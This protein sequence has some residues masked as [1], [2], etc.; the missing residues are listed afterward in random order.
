MTTTI[1]KPATGS[2][3]FSDSGC[4]FISRDVSWVDFNARVLEEAAFPENFLLDRLRFIAI[5]SSN[6]DEFFAVRAAGLQ[7][8][9][10]AGIMTG[11][12]AGNSPE[13]Q[14][15]IIRQK[16]FAGIEKQYRILQYELLPLLSD[17][18]IKLSIWK[19]L[20]SQQQEKLTALFI[21]DIMPF[22]TPV[23]IEPEKNFPVIHSGVIAIAVSLK[24]PRSKDKKTIILEVPE[25]LDRFIRI[26]GRS[27]ENEQTFIL[28]EEV[29][30]A[31]ITRFFPHS[32]VE[33]AQIFRLIRDMDYTISPQDGNNLINVLRKKLQQCAISTPVKLDYSTLIHDSKL[34]KLLIKKLNLTKKQCFPIPG[35]LH[36]KQFEELIIKSNRKNLLEPPWPSTL[37]SWYLKYP[38]VIEAIRDRKNLLLV[39]PYHDFAPTLRFLQETANDPAVVAIKQTLYRVSG[40]SPVVQALLNAARNGKQVTVLVELK[41]RFNEKSNIKWAEMLTHA[42]ANVIYGIP[43]LKVHCKALLVTRKENNTSTSYLHLG[44]GNYNDVTAK[45]YTDLGLFTNDRQLTADTERL[46]DLFS[47]NSKEPDGRQKISIAPFNLREKLTALIRRETA[48]GCRGRIIA[49]I[50][51]FSDPALITLIHEAANAG[52]KIDLIV[53]GICCLSPLPGEKNLR[54]ISIIDRYLEHSRIFYFANAGKEELYAS[55]ADWMPRNLD[56]RIETMFPITD[57]ESKAVIMQILQFH[58]EDNCKQRQL[59]PT[60]NYTT[61]FPVPGEEKKRSQQQ[62]QNFLHNL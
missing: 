60:G 29:I 53:R 31:N 61:C 14:M 62:I 57:P 48:L 6:L 8:L 42:G 41:A 37:P 46:F 49:K 32:E 2:A 25:N 38:S 36:L 10:R 21:R 40:N 22:L 56:R 27:G 43:G 54:I 30:L 44:T 59:L 7:H 3:T 58:L 16:A 13:T 55:S 39:H 15:S 45:S 50:N 4:R 35:A 28:L 9:L 5:Y 24:F 18:G 47:G 12:P 19:E 51:S 23:T 26:S 34:Q 1:R 33:A 11:D 52:V 20:S 17:N